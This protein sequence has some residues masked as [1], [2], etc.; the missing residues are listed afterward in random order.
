MKEMNKEFF[1]PNAFEGMADFADIQADYR[2]NEGQLLTSWM[3]VFDKNDLTRKKIHRQAKALITAVRKQTVSTISIES[4][5]LQYQLNTEEG[6]ALMCL[7]EAL[8]RVPDRQTMNR[9]IQDKLG[10]PDWHKAQASPTTLGHAMQWGLMLTGKVLKQ[11]EDASHM[12]QV[13]KSLVVKMG[14]P[15]LRTAVQQFMRLFANQ[16]VLGETLPKALKVAKKGEAEGYSYS[17]DMLG[18]AALTEADAKR[19]FESYLA[20]IESIPND[21]STSMF[22]RPGISVK[23]SAIFSRYEIQHRADV[24]RVLYPR[25]QALCVAAK[26]QNIGLVIDAEESER[27]IL[28]LDVLEHLMQDPNLHDWPGLGLAVQA[29]QKR[30]LKTIHWLIKQ[31]R[32][33]QRRLMVR[34][35]KGAYW[36]TEIKHAQVM[37]WS[38]YPVFTEKT[39]TDL[40]YLVCAHQMIQAQDAIYPMFATHNVLTVLTLQHW[41]GKRKDFEFQRLHGMGEQLYKNVM[42][43]GDVRCRVYAPVGL[44]DDLLPYLVRRLLE[45]GATSSFVNQI[46][47]QRVPI[48][49]MLAFDPLLHLDQS[50]LVANPHIPLPADLFPSGRQNSYGD[51]LSDHLNIKAMAKAMDET[52]LTQKKVV[53]LVEG[54]HQDAGLVEPVLNPADHRMTIAMAHAADTD[55]VMAAIT[56]AKAKCKQWQKVPLAARADCLRQAADQLESERIAFIKLLILEAGKTWQDAVDEVREAVDFLRYYADE[57]VSKLGPEQLPGPTGESNQLTYVARGVAACISPWNFPLAIFIGQISAALVAGNVVVAKPANQTVTVA[58]KMVELMYAVGVPKF[59]IQVVF[60]STDAVAKPLIADERIDLVMMTGSTQ[61]AKSIQQTLANRPGAIIPLIAE[62][63]GQNVMI[64]DSSALPEQ[65]VRDVV[66]SGFR[67]AG[68]RCSAC[69]VL[70]VHEDVADK[71]ITMLKGAMEGLVLGDPK[72]MATDIGPVIDDLAMKRLSDHQAHLNEIGTCIY[73]MTLPESCQNGTFFAPCL[74]EI[75][76]LAQLKQEVFGPIV[77]VIRY[78][79]KDFT[80]MLDSIN[81]TGY[82]LTFGIHSRIQSFVDEVVAAVHVG[83]VY[84]NRNMIGAQVGVQPFGGQG[85]SGTGP[86]AGGPH[87]LPRLCHE[88]TITVNTAAVGGD[89][90]LMN[91]K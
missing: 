15:A 37:G 58:T 1:T 75:K 3:R 35:V 81:A 28:S 61:T 87:Y 62:T 41:L 69:R 23:L 46:L 47:D 42:A 16:F 18:E 59:A 10:E 78:K 24:M 50:E 80:A 60:G 65:V 77:H 20:A 25:L 63:G 43:E 71:I 91:A 49:E 64:V 9:L 52:P 89:V 22:D 34:L 31:A 55:V 8:L 56:T 4:L 30:S 57:A 5:L 12:Q 79:S 82:G 83:N 32:K 45:N 2:A 72:A 73:Q 66:D 86:K 84:V 14:Q 26:K 19:Y 33:Y 53:S 85:L 21:D 39:H 38:D 27:L 54:K 51:D 48:D 70:M 29:Y 67:S 90:A 7:A 40:A 17:F 74:Y 11:T 36:D 44:H 6:I 13:L 88:K 68:Q 76:D